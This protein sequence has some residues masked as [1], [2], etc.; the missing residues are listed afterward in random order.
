[1]MD[2]ICNVCG[3]ELC[4]HPTYTLYGQ[5]GKWRWRC[6]LCGEAGEGA[7]PTSYYVPMYE[8]EVVNP[9][10]HEW[11]GFDAC[12]ECSEASLTVQ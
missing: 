4:C 5:D 12:K 10:T 9:D 3:V 6:S 1:M 11:G 8:G 2:G 7:N